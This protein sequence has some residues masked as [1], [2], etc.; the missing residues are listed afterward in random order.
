MNLNT[1]QDVS[2]IYD[3]SDVTLLADIFGNLIETSHK[4]SSFNPFLFV[5]LPGYLW[6][7]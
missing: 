4:K 1:S 3:K 2:L 6:D 5:S 7:A